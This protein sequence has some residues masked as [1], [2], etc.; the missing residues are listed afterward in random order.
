MNNIPEG[1]GFDAL[2]APSGFTCAELSVIWFMQMQTDNTPVS[3]F[4]A[5]LPSKKR[6]RKGTPTEDVID[7]SEDCECEYKGSAITYSQTI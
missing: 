1:F 3:T 7:L 4:S 6:R 5:S 2:S